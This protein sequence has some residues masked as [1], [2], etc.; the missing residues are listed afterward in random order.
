MSWLTGDGYGY[1]DGHGYA[2]Y[3]TFV[4]G[5]LVPDE[6]PWQAGLPRIEN[7][8]RLCFFHPKS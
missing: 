3:I 6:A 1:S 2:S 8:E 5:V 4:L 7:H